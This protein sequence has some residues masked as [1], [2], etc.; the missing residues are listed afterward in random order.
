MGGS[1]SGRGLVGYAVRTLFVS[2]SLPASVGVIISGWIFSYF[3]QDD[4]FFGRDMLQ[5]LSFFLVLLTA[6][7]GISLPSLKWQHFVSA[8][9]VALCAGPLPDTALQLFGSSLKAEDLNEIELQE[10][11]PMYTMTVHLL[12]QMTKIQPHEE[13]LAAGQLVRF[14]VSMGRA[15]FISHQWLGCGH[16]DPQF[17]QMKVLQDALRNLISGGSEVCVDLISEAVYFRSTGIPAAEWTS[18]GLFLWYDYFSCPQLERGASGLTSPHLQKAI[19]SIPVYV[20]RCHYFIALCPVLSSPDK[21]ETFSDYTWSKRG[22]CC[23]ELTVR[24]LTVNQGRENV[25]GIPFTF[26]VCP[27]QGALCFKKWI[28]FWGL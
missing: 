18:A 23:V 6:G 4:I 8:A 28:H 17:Q 25:V 7:L 9:M 20:S 2:L 10:T 26:F 19:E 16:P 22:W 3:I 27:V 12:L 24:E 5:E 14:E 11:F 13:L 1:Q 21:E 15:A